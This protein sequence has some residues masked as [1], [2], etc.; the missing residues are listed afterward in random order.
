VKKRSRT[1]PLPFKT[2]GT[3]VIE[4]IDI[5]KHY[6]PIK[7]NNGVSLTIHDGSI[8]AILGENGAGKSTLMKILSGYNRKSSGAIHVNG[9]EVDFTS[10]AVAASFGIGM[11]YQD[12]MDFPQ[13]TVLDNFMIGQSKGFLVKKKHF[14]DRFKDISTNLGFDMDPDIPVKT[15]TVGERQQLEIIRLISIGTQVLILDEPTTGISDSQKDTLFSALTRLTEEGKSIVLVS[16][17]LEDVEMLCDRIT[18]LRHGK[19][20]GY[21]E[22]PFHTEKLLEMMFESHSKPPQRLETRPGASVMRFDSV[23]SKGGRVGL[24]NLSVSIHEHEVIGLAGLEGSGQ[25]V[26]LRAAAGL[27]PVTSGSIH[28]MQQDVTGKNH[29]FFQ[30]VGITFLPS[31]RLEEGLISGM[32][33]MQHYALNKRPKPFFVERK[34]AG[35]QARESINTFN[36]KARPGSAVET[37]SG[38]N[39]QRLLLSLL[40]SKP[41]LLLLENPTRGL[42]LDSAYFIWKHLQSFCRDHRTAIVFTSSEID[43]ILMVSDRIL[44]FYDGEMV[45]DR[46]TSETNLSEIG[47]AIAGKLV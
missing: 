35:Y 5:H 13:L 27:I 21:M 12:P 6:G 45:L 43:E 26:F 4:L 11:L 29:V 18:V 47:A 42:D 24:R 33:L 39:Q 36:I 1:A 23:S 34:Q 22:R 30:H 19:V 3:D 8:H 9:V 10:T 17:K 25:G 7:A 20:S 28:H 31:S 40:P 37:L 14:L 41:E 15:L 44:V 32:N 16:H 38:G 2:K 46:I